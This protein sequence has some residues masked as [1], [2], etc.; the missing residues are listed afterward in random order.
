MFFARIAGTTLMSEVRFEVVGPDG[1]VIVITRDAC[2]A[3]R[4]AA[5]LNSDGR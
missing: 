5:Q 3:A 1:A 2:K 4:I